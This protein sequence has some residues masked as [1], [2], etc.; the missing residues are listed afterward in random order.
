MV[1][2]QHV[3]MNRA[4]VLQRCFAEL[5]KVTCIIRGSGK[6][7]IRGGGIIRLE[8][9]IPPSPLL[10]PLLRTSIARGEMATSFL[11]R[12]NGAAWAPG[13]A[14]LQGGEKES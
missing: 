8:Q 10:A 3:R 9:T 7:E 14:F 11:G 5:S 12:P 1:S 4:S 2:H 6:A 13:N